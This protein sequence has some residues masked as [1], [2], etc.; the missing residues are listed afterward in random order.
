MK[1][2]TNYYVNL[3]LPSTA[4]IMCYTFI[5][6]NTVIIVLGHQTNIK[7]EEANKKMTSSKNM[8]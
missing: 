7:P 8:N 1:Y 2:K 3:T 4:F 6:V 5:G